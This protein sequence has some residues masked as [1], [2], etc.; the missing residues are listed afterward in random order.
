MD[1]RNRKLAELLV[2]YSCGVQ[3][4]EKLLVESVGFDALDLVHEIVSEAT[5]LGAHVYTNF[6]SDTLTRRFL[7]DAGEEQ[8]RAQAK[9]DLHRMKEM[10]CFI[11]IRASANTMEMSDVP[12][13]KNGL[14]SKHYVQP[15]HMKTRVP[16][17]RWV[18]LRYPNNAMA[19]NAKKPLHV[20][21]DFYFDV[22]TLDYA[23]MSKAMDPLKALM[24]A[25]DRVEIKGPKT[26]LKFSIRGLSSIKCDGKLNI[27]DGELYTAPVRDSIDGTICF[28]TPALFE[29]V[30]FDEIQLRFK[31]GKVVEAD[32][33]ANTGRLN[34]ILDRDRGARYVGEFS[35]GF[36][37]YVTEAMLDALFDEKI[38]GSLHMALG[39]A[40]DDC[41]NGNRSQI[42][43]DLVHIQRPEKGGG[44]IHFD[45][46]LLRKDGLFVPKELKGLNPDRLK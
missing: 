44:E 40:Y 23:K 16:K 1:P 13:E 39:N 43:W 24:D 17:T 41:F 12:S 5:R 21:E 28:N 46:K 15:V 22:C 4:G 19:Q 7:H 6:R 2:Q 34:A 31:N 20:F 8:I 9:Y 45:G 37:P 30:V 27:P 38:A 3:K 18:V 14:W 25:T 33:G 11:G 35:L 42:H 32:A 29:G 36:N 26:D 10:D